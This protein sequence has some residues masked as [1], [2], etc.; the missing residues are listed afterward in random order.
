MEINFILH[1]SSTSTVSNISY[2][3]QLIGRFVNYSGL[4]WRVYTDWL[5]SFSLDR[6]TKSCCFLEIPDKF[7][8][9]PT[10]YYTEL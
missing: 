3:M 7:R 8:A 2:C 9:V 6:E 1:V 5:E 4:W 10:V